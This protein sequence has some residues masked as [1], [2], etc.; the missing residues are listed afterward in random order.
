MR[1]GRRGTSKRLPHGLTLYPEASNLSIYLT[2]Y[3]GRGDP[4]KSEI[5]V[6]NSDMIIAIM[7]SAF[8]NEKRKNEC[9]L[10]CTFKK[11]MIAIGL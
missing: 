7:F 5:F 3:P 2:I 9:R 6:W 1:A 10:N 8:F 4:P 11:I